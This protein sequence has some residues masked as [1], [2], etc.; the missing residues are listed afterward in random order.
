[1]HVQ[2]DPPHIEHNIEKKEAIG[3]MV[4]VKVMLKGVYLVLRITML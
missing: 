2:C 1:M 3:G 4:C